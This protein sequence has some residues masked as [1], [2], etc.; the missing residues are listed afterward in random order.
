MKKFMMKL[1]VL[2]AVVAGVVA[3]GA[4]AETFLEKLAAD[5]HKVDSSP[6]AAGG[7][8]I[9]QLG[10]DEY[11]HVFTNAAVEE[12]FTARQML[13]ARLLLIGGGGAGGG[14]AYYGSGGGGAGGMLEVD[15]F[16]LAAD[17]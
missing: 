15:S 11:V 2:A 4:N 6:Y 5:S 13:N 16:I 3:I 17:S 8:I 10:E 9:L 12:T 1:K 7:D 14:T